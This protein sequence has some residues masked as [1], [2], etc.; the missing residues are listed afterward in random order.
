MS[1]N[2]DTLDQRQKITLDNAPYSV[3][4]LGRRLGQALHS[5][6][7]TIYLPGNRHLVLEGAGD[8][9]LGASMELRNYRALRRILRGGAIG[10]A[11]AYIDGDWNTT[12]LPGLLSLLAGN[13]A[14]F[15]K[16]L[17]GNR[18]YRLWNRLLHLIRR[19]SRSGS[20]RNIA[21]HY[22]LGN[23]FY[24]LWLDRSMTYSAGCFASPEVS[25]EAA[26][27]EK[28]R[29]LADNLGLK[30]GDHVLEI[31]CGWGGFA[32]FAAG[33]YG[34]R[35]TGVTLSREQLS[36]ARRHI[37]DAGLED[38]CDFRYQD[39]RDIHGR[40][41]HIVSIEMFEAVGEEHWPVYFDRLSRL[42]K[43]NGRIGL[44]IITIAD[45]RFEDYRRNSD[46]IQKY[47]FPGG[48]LPSPEKVSL[49]AK[50]NGF[51][52]TDQQDFGTD[53]AETLKRW[54]GKFLSRQAEI[55]DLGYPE[56]FLRMWD[57]YLCYCEAGFNRKTIDVS[58]F[59]LE[60]QN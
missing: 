31:G 8:K 45:D 30:P 32:E 29:R 59:I 52:L 20:R 7:L 23:D 11:E 39:Y 24:S 36:R 6:R 22:D 2:V 14:H 38:L 51:I 60:R 12:D 27:K 33:T 28:Y 57:Y 3:R 35:V 21:Y 5:G 41:D 56:S 53:Y 54:R 48:L 42:L 10:F 55:R 18:I 16:R 26:Q 50:N 37:R 58:H 47:I 17:G 40:F 46:F 34:C 44:Q 13:L 19:N 15:R 25:L 1:S 49:L 9:H 4:R 43:E